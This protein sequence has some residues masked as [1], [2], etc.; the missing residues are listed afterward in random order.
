MQQGAE[1]L[2]LHRLLARPRVIAAA[3]EAGL[4]VRVYTVN[5]ALEMMR[6]ADVGVDGQF[7]DEVERLQEVLG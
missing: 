4:A 5:D 6:F 7:T 1:G 2:H 3:H